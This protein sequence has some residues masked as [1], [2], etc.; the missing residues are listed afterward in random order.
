MKSLKIYLITIPL[1][2]VW[3]FGCDKTPNSALSDEQL[4][5]SAIEETALDEDNEY[6]LDWGVDDGD[7]ANMY[8]GFATFDLGKA[9]VPINNVV[10]FGR[11]IERRYPRTLIIRRISQDSVLVITERILEGKF[12]IFDQISENNSPSDT[13]GITRKPL[14]HS[15][16]RHAIFVRKNSADLTAVAD[17]RLRFKLAGISLSRGESRPYNTI[18]IEQI[19]IRSENGYSGSFDDPYRKIFNIPEDLPKF[20]RGEVVTVTAYVSNSTPNPVYIHSDPNETE[21]L[22]LHFGIGPRDRARKRFEFLGSENG[23]NKYQVTWRVREPVRFPYHCVVD[24]IDN[25]TIYDNDNETY[26]YNSTT[27][28]FPYR[29]LLTEDTASQ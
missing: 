15:V 17:P 20:V 18:T 28:G 26:P 9:M 12:V 19:D 4:E 13:I 23:V 21:T 6:L 14:K 29:V 5:L 3:M 1:A 7:E 2:L 16:K 27:L 22:L 10:R 11:K 24:A 25:G 8:D